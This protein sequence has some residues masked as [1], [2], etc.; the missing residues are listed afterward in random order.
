MCALTDHRNHAL[1]IPY[2]NYCFLCKR[3]GVPL[4]VLGVLV[5][6]LLHFGLSTLILYSNVCLEIKSEEHAEEI[7]EDHVVEVD[8]PNDLTESGKIE[9]KCQFNLKFFCLIN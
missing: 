1:L 9:L 2:F 7:N 6:T 5:K 8:D 4:S 3:D